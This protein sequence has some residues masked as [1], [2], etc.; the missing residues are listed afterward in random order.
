[1]AAATGRNLL[2]APVKGGKA[3]KSMRVKSKATPVEIASQVS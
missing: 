1:M 3:R 2:P